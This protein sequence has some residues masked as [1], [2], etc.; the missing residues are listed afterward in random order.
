MNHP[1]E[2]RQAE[3]KSLDSRVSKH[4]LH[5]LSIR[6]DWIIVSLPLLALT[7]LLWRSGDKWDTKH[8]FRSAGFYY[9]P[10]NSLDYLGII[11]TADLYRSSNI[12]GVN[13]SDDLSSSSSHM[14]SSPQ[15]ME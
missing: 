4:E 13:G 11:P 14:R 2:I 7:L 12:P 1:Y 9:L 15:S 8:T 3:D 6:K 10:A 5:D